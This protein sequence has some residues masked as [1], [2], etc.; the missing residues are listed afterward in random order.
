MSVF[1]LCKNTTYMYINTV[2]T[3][4]QMEEVHWRI[5]TMLMVIM[6]EPHVRYY[7]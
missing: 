2:Y 1:M 6:N 7:I 5:W 3:W 4:A